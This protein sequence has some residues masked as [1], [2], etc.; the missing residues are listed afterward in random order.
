MGRLRR[1][2]HDLVGRAPALVQTGAREARL[3]L[4]D[5]HH[6]GQGP[7]RAAQLRRHRPARSPESIS[8]SPGSEGSI[9]SSVTGPPLRPPPGLGLHLAEQPRHRG[10][11][12]GA[13][14]EDPQARR[15]RHRRRRW[16]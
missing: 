13:V 7:Q 10:Q 9:S 14:D 15:P 1:W 11:R 4:L 2:S 12:L 3:D 16:A 5:L 6:A 8:T